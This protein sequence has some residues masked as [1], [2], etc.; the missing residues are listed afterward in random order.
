MTTVQRPRERPPR[1]RATP[2]RSF[3]NRLTAHTPSGALGAEGALARPCAGARWSGCFEIYECPTAS[4]SIVT[5]TMV[6]GRGARSTQMVEITE[7][8]LRLTSAIRHRSAADRD[9]WWSSHVC[10][11]RTPRS[12]GHRRCPPA[13]RSIRPSDLLRLCESRLPR[14]LRRFQRLLV[15]GDDLI[16]A[17]LPFSRVGLEVVGAMEKSGRSLPNQ[18]HVRIQGCHGVPHLAMRSSPLLEFTRWYQSRLLDLR[19]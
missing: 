12:R 14:V 8:V 5:N 18:R 19:P 10:T 9:G 4:P 17:T 15:L 3:D 2:P 11:R 6:S 13:R 7:P 1:D 16:P